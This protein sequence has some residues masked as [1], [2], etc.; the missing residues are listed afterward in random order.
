MP[1]TLDGTAGVNLPISA[2]S[3]VKFN[4]SSSGTVT[5]KAPATAGTNTLTLPAA[6][7]TVSTTGFSVAMSIVFGG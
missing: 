2:T 6:T 5:V 1:L 4:G 7:G 3:S